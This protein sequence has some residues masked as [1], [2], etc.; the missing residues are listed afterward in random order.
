MSSS[1]DAFPFMMPSILPSRARRIATATASRGFA[2]GV[3][4]NASRST[5]PASAASRI[6]LSVEMSAPLHMPWPITSRKRNDH[7][8]ILVYAFGFEHYF[9]LCSLLLLCRNFDGDGVAHFHGAPEAQVLAEVNRAGPRKHSPKDRVGR[10][11]DRRRYRC[12]LARLDPAHD[13]AETRLLIAYSGST[14]AGLMSP[15]ITAKSIMSCSVSV[16]SS[17]AISP[18]LISSKV[19]FSMSSATVELPKEA[20]RYLQGVSFDLTRI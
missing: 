14:C 7:F 9:T 15:D 8:A 18:I 3:I 19:R 2:A 4:S 12:K 5:L 13:F 1:V 17:V 16:R 11:D 10:I 20:F 6:T